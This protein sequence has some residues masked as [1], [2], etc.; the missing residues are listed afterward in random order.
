MATISVSLPSDGSTADVADY[1]TP[2]NTLVSEFN[3]NIDN[4]NI[5]SAAAIDGSKLADNSIN[6]GSKVSTWDG[7]IKVTDSWAYA[8]A[9]TITVP[10]DATTKYVVGDYI[11]LTQSAAVK[12]FQITAVAA[13]VL[14]VVGITTETV[15]NAAIS[16][17]YYCKVVPVGLTTA[18]RAWTPTYAN[19]TPGSATVVAKYI[20]IGKTVHFRLNITLSGS[21]MGS[22]PTF[23]LPVTSVTYSTNFPIGFAQFLDANVAP[24]NGYAQWA[25]TTTATIRSW[26]TNNN[27]GNLSSTAPFTWAN[28]DQISINGTYEAA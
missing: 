4:A 24:Y 23:T 26:D 9:T 20:Q 17:I 27:A 13:T 1:N 22:V 21:T 28:S 14:T 11:K 5:K 15:A 6:L 12:Y 2:L 16:D 18:W 7:W 19:F 25:S 3:G 10:T 8:S